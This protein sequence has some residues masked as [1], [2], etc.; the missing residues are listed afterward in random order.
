[1][2]TV[3]SQEFATKHQSNVSEI[4][5]TQLIVLVVVLVNATSSGGVNITV[6]LSVWLVVL[7][8]IGNWNY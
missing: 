3:A 4:H 2:G 7:F 6:C 5:S 8:H 1:M